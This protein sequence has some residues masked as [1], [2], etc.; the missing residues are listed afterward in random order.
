MQLLVEIAR[1]GVQGCNASAYA[2]ITDVQYRCMPNRLVSLIT[3]SWF[4]TGVT[5]PSAL[6]SLDGGGF[7]LAYLKGVDCS[8]LSGARS[9]R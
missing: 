3:C 5:A 4:L 1:A 6:Q 9:A 7:E 2:D 8:V